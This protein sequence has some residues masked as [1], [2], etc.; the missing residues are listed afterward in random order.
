MVQLAVN[1][2]GADTLALGQEV[3]AD[4]IDGDVTA[5]HGLEVLQKLRAAPGVVLVFIFQEADLPIRK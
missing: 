1:G 5:L 3:G 4:I 2:G